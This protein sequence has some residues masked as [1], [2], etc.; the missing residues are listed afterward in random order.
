MHQFHT[1]REQRFIDLAAT[2]ADDFAQRAAQHDEDGSFP[3]ENYVRLKNSGYTIMTIPEELGGNGASL[4]ERIKAQERLG[5]GCGPTALAINMHF[6]AVGLLIDLWRKFQDSKRADILLQI[7]AERLICGGSASEPDNAIPVLRPR[8]TAER[9]DGGWR[10]SGRKI[11]ST[12]SIALDR[13]FS[14]ALWQEGPEG[15]TIVSFLIP[16]DTPGLTFKDDWYT[17]G[18]RATASRGTE[19]TNVFVP[20]S[21]VTL[22]RPAFTRG[23]IT[24]LFLR[25]PFTIAAPYVGI[26][27]AARDFVVEFMRERP[28]FPLNKPMSHLPSVYNKVGEMDML[29]ETARA[30]LW[31][32]AAEADIEEPQT[33][34]H[35]SV[36]ART[37]AMENAVRVVDLA[38]RAVGGAS[39]FKRFPLERYYRDV[40]AA[41]FHPVGTDQALELLGKTAFGIPMLD[42]DAI[43]A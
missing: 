19:L 20:A 31:K 8:A 39:Y 14:E 42:D 2:L 17:M 24:N 23:G 27:V 34:A 21:A 33:W 3:H 41:L 30:M 43:W 32:A 5:Q 25:A 11:F 22:L 40:R 26:A 18:M 37:V 9:V 1:P 28:R 10:V 12:Q 7:A 6:N 29:I 35:K 15:E 4:L 38:L 13:Y 36:T 16:P